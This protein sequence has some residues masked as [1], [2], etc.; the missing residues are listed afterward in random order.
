MPHLSEEI[1]EIDICLRM[2]G[3]FPLRVQSLVGQ[4]YSRVGPTL[5][6]QATAQIELTGLK[7]EGD[8]RKLCGRQAG[9]VN[10]GGVG[11]VENT[12]SEIFIKLRNNCNT[13]EYSQHSTKFSP[14]A[15]YV[16]RVQQIK[17]FENVVE[18]ML[19]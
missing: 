11:E 19:Q 5:R 13:L 12:L 2:E 6:V 10:L 4:P 17:I 3:Q 14:K 1:S 18:K 9:C 7:I 16:L 8:V 15:A